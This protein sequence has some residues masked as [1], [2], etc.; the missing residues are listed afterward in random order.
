MG[1]GTTQLGKYIWVPKPKSDLKEFREA[2]KLGNILEERDGYFND[3][4]LGKIQVKQ[5]AIFDGSLSINEY[6]TK[7]EKKATAD[8]SYVSNARMTLR[9]LRWFGWVT[10]AKTRGKFNL[11]PRGKEYLDFSGK[12]PDHFSDKDE[13]LMMT[14]DILSFKYYSGN[15]LSQ[16]REVK[17]RPMLAILVALNELGK[18]HNHE[19]SI[20]ALTDTLETE[21]DKIIEPVIRMREGK[22]TI[23]NEYRKLGWD[24]E[25][26]SHVTGV[27]DGPKVFCSI[28]K[29]LML[30]E[31][32]LPND[33]GKKYYKRVYKGRRINSAPRNLFKITKRGREVLPVLIA[34][35]PIWWEDL[36]AEPINLNDWLDN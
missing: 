23:Q 4:T 31:N 14:Y 8:Q 10:R 36:E 24:P 19:I 35:K 1:K 26:K 3:K 30:V 2:L 27:Y 29:Q 11:T 20:C 12:W 16:D 22:S 7:Y 6:F 34:P 21:K 33:E 28:L 9:L 25:Q 13:H 15:D 17:K 5:G 18:L 32:D